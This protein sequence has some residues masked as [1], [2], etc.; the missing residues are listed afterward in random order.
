SLNNDWTNWDDEGYVLQ[1]NL[2]KSINLTS[3]FS[4]Y[5]M[6]NYHP[7]TVLIQAI[8]YHFFRESASG[9][10]TVSLLL[11]LVNALL[12]FYT[13]LLLTKKSVVAFICSLLFAV[14]PLHVES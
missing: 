2:V 5:E 9:F 14:H 7:I 13:V 12:L 8:E 3:I 1:N 6:G 10:H 11:H 4:S